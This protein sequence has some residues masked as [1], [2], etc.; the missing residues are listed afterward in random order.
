MVI[1]GRADVYIDNEG[2][3][4]ATV[5]NNSHRVTDYNKELFATSMVGYS[6][7]YM[8]SPMTSRGELVMKAYIPVT[9]GNTCFRVWVGYEYKA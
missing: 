3:L 5:K 1:K 9:I 4:Y 6:S 8:I 2:E 7:W